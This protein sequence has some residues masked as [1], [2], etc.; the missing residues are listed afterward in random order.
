MD[1]PKPTPQTVTDV[2]SISTRRLSP[3]EVVAV[4]AES[5]AFGVDVEAL[6]HNLRLTPAQRLAMLQAGLRTWRT[7]RNS[8]PL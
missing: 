3:S 4:L 8:R 5:K 7:L 1:E 6:R 2:S